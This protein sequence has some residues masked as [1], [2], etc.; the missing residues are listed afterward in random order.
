MIVA[1]ILVIEMM[2]AE[3]RVFVTMVLKIVATFGQFL[4]AGLGYWLRDWKLVI[5]ASTVPFF[6]LLIY[7]FFLPESVRSVL[8][9]FTLTDGDIFLIT[10]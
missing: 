9:Y 4:V 10:K 3:R 6:V 8:L 7:W 2:P 5:I 1:Y